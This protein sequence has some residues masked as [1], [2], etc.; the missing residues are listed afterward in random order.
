MLKERDATPWTNLI[1]TRYFSLGSVKR[2]RKI[3]IMEYNTRNQRQTA[4]NAVVFETDT[5]FTLNPWI[6]VLY[7]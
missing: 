5:S 3:T 7:K 4:L 2:Y 6:N 1:Y